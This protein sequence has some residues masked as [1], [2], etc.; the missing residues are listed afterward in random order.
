MKISRVTLS[1]S[2]PAPQLI[3]LKNKVLN[4]NIKIEILKVIKIQIITLIKGIIFFSISKNNQKT[5]NGKLIIL[6]RF[7]FLLFFL[8]YYQKNQ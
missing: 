4:I 7:I 1:V 3:K 6:F 2:K 5:K 8:V